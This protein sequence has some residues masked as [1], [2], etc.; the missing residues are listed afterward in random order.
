MATFRIKDD[1]FLIVDNKF[2]VGDGAC[3]CCDE[4]AD[5]NSFTHIMIGVINVN[6]VTDDDFELRIDGVLVATIIET[7]LTGPG[8]I[9]RGNVYAPIGCDDNF[10]RDADGIL[11]DVNSECGPPGNVLF[12]NSAALTPLINGN[13]MITLVSIADN[14][15]G[16]FGKIAVWGCRETCTPCLI[17]VESYAGGGTVA[18]L[19]FNFNNGFLSR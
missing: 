3:V 1:K 13:H 10:N 11:I 14:G 8:G 16:N 15:Y 5:L 6:G 4:C 2:A 17:F 18:E 19:I 12:N 9:Y 7:D